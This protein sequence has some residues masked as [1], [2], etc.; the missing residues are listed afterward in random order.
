M[1]AVQSVFT[2]KVGVRIFAAWALILAAVALV[3]IL[4]LTNSTELYSNE[5][6]NQLVVWAI[7]LLNVGFGAGF[8][9]SAYGLWQ[10]KKW[11]RLLFLWII[12][13]WAILNL[14]GLFVPFLAS[15]HTTFQLVGSTI[16]YGAALIVPLL[17]FNIPGVKELFYIDTQK[18]TP[19]GSK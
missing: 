16:R 7:M 19:Q 2:P 14:V 10:Q 6:G 11:G 4:I 17:Y 12:A 1:E 8:G 15:R 3:N 5:Y 13:A 9:V 18:N